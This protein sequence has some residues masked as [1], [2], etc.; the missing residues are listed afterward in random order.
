MESGLSVVG[1]GGERLT[2]GGPQQ[3]IRKERE[4]SV[5]TEMRR[6]RQLQCKT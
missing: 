5:S 2:D 3:T 1:G 4:P 6:A